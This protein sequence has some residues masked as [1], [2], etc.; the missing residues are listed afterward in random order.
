MLSFAMVLRRLD[1]RKNEN[2][3]SLVIWEEMPI[4]SLR[5]LISHLPWVASRVQTNSV[6]SFRVNC[7]LRAINGFY[8]SAPSCLLF[9]R[10]FCSRPSSRFSILLPKSISWHSD[11]TIFPTARVLTPASFGPQCSFPSSWR[12]KLRR[13]TRASW[14]TEWRLWEHRSSHAS[15]D[16]SFVDLAEIAADQME[17][18]AE[19]LQR[20][21]NVDVMISVLYGKFIP[22]YLPSF[23]THSFRIC[24]WWESFLF[25]FD[26]VNSYSIL[27]HQILWNQLKE[28]LWSFV[29]LRIFQ[30]FFSLIILSS[31]TSK[32]SNSFLSLTIPP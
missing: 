14:W 8:F 18:V 9:G 7:C 6:H 12:E 20:K 27:T 3:S 30:V 24:C 19:L 28:M 4:N 1:F 22:K 16:P 32:E 11:H 23:L 13:L 2:F 29:Q 5:K 26:F 17:K 25:R 10:C 15:F 21:L 31:L